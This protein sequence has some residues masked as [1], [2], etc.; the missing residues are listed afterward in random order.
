MNRIATFAITILVLS[1]LSAC[2]E[3]AS[4]PFHEGIDLQ[5]RI[6]SQQRRIDQGISSG[7]LTRAEADVLQD[8]LNWIKQEYS[9]ARDDGRISGEE[10]NRIEGSLDQNSKMITDQSKNPI[11]TIYPPSYES[12]RSMSIDERIG[13]QQHRIDQGIASGELTLKEAEVIQENLNWIK[14]RYT[15]FRADG[16]LTWQEQRELEDYLDTNGYMIFNKK[17]NPARRLY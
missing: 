8:N 16:T 9:K 17:H 7:E 12:P 15:R 2:L 4:R 14:N 13:N 5:T 3:P 1:S 10:W 11:R 6:D